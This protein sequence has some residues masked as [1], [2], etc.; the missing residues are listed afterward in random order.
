MPTTDSGFLRSPNLSTVSLAMMQTAIGFARMS[1][2][3]AYGSFRVIRTV[4]LSGAST[5]SSEASM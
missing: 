1:R 3:Q 4:Y 2:N 5:F